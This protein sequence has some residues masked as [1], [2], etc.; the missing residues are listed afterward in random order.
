VPW[1]CVSPGRRGAVSEGRPSKGGGE[2]GRSGRRSGRR[3]GGGGG[4]GSGGETA[5][6][7]FLCLNILQFWTQVGATPNCRTA[8]LCCA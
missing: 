3:G 5:V 7:Q 6:D 8:R 2:G 1:C 4:G